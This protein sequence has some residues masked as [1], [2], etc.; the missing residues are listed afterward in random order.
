MFSV[1]TCPEGWVRRGEFCYL[2]V[3]ED[4]TWQDASCYCTHKKGNLT[5][6]HNK[7]ENDII[8]GKFLLT[9]AL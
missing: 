7:E 4:K 5:S 9:F 8:Q 6:I 1:V 2:L 3:R